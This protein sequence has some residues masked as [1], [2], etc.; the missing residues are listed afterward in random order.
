LSG[1][2]SFPVLSRLG[3]RVRVSDDTK[4]SLPPSIPNPEPDPGEAPR[5]IVLSSCIGAVFRLAA[6]VED[7]T[8]PWR[9]FEPRAIHGQLDQ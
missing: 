5:V 6:Q 2:S 4:T 7:G 9:Q 3:L 1:L 8:F